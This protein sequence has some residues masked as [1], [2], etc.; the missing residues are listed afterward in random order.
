MEGE[1]LAGEY[2]LRNDETRLAKAERMTNE[3]TLP[4]FEC[5]MPS[6]KDPLCPGWRWTSDFVL[7][8][9]ERS[10][11]LCHE[12]KTREEFQNWLQQVDVGAS[13]DEARF[14][15]E[16]LRL[17]SARDDC[18]LRTCFP[19][20]FTASALV[21]SGDGATTLLTHHRLLDRW[22]QFGGH[23]DGNPDLLA[24]ALREAAEESGVA[25]LV[26]MD[27]EP[28]DLDIHV[29]P[30]NPRRGEPEHFHYDVRFLLRAPRDAVPVPSDESKDLRWFT[31]DEMRAL[32][33]ESGLRR[34]VEKWRRVA[35]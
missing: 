21:L 20:H 23:C 7:R 30:A 5:R 27:S 26:P 10:D 33:E 1:S 14:R 12:V 35:P 4:N 31:P 9:V 29:I 17:L 22:L 6:R 2:Q 32:S 24:G 19:A 13:P 16:M 18:F 34:L 8:H 25:G 28:V 3:Q 11:V 15:D